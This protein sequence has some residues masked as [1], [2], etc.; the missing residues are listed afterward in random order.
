MDE[1]RVEVDS[2]SLICMHLD[3]RCAHMR[4]GTFRIRL[5]AIRFGMLLM[6]ALNET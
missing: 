6:H 3:Y 1:E 5:S 2:L 4:C